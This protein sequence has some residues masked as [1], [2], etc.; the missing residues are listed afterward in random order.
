MYIK[1]IT[2]NVQH[3]LYR[4]LF[5]YNKNIRILSSLFCTTLKY[6]NTFYVHKRPYQVMHIKYTTW[7]VQYIYYEI[8]I[9]EYRKKNEIFPLV[10]VH[11]KYASTSYE[12]KIAYQAMNTFF[13]R[14]PFPY[15]KKISK[16]YIFLIEQ[17]VHKY[18]VFT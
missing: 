18:K 16:I 2:R 14:F 10:I 6:I 17:K 1:Y 13:T 8:S 4:C 7:S 9:S 5:L 15:I 3:I 11:K 12:R